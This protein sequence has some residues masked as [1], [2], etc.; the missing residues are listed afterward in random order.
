MSLEDTIGTGFYPPNQ[1]GKKGE[2][3]AWLRRIKG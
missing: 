3:F 1:I 2:G